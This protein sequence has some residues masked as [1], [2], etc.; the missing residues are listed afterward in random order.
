[1]CVEA[2]VAVFTAV[3]AQSVA[4]LGFGLD[5]VIEL[6]SATLVLLRFNRSLQINERKASRVA[7]ILLFALAVFIVAS[8]ILALANSR[9]K[10]EPSYLGIALLIVAAFAM[11]WL[12][13]RKRAL[14]AKTKSGS[15]RADA[16]QSSMCAYLAS[17][18][19]AA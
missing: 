12:A 6:A 1:M 16:V 4:L 7:G 19:L 2:A 17:I 10:P 3:R 8:S 9:F 5:S 18:A 15:L 11:P 13:R 14:A